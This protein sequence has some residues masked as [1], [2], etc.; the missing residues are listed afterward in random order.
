M[1]Y[2]HALYLSEKLVSKKDTIIEKIEQDKWQI[3]KYLIVLTKDGR[4]H[5]E[6]Y[7]AVMLL[8]KVFSKED[9]FVVGIADGYGGALELV[10]QITQEV[11]DETQGT[12]IRGYLL[13]KQKEYETEHV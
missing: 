12:D 3:D 2:Y 13:N 7:S 10:Q 9:L 11:Y 1:K 5:L 8:Q 4:N 6:F